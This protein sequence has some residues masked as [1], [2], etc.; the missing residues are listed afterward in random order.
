MAR[1]SWLMR[2]TPAAIS[3]LIDFGDMLYGTLAA[4]VAVACDGVSHDSQDIV[5][6]ACDVIAG[7]DAVLALEEDEID[8]V[9][10]LICARNAM[11]ATIAARDWP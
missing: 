10:D 2:K 8:V 11:T 3:G 6:P 5:T 7:F 4:E 1:M 9:F